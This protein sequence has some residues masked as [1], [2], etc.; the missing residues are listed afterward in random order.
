MKPKIHINFYTSTTDD[1]N[2]YAYALKAEVTEV[3]GI[4]DENGNP[5]PRIFIFQRGVGIMPNG[6]KTR[7]VFFGI[8][9]PLDMQEIPG[10]EPDLDNDLPFYRLNEVTL[11]F[12]CLSD[13]EQA[14]KD[15]DGDITALIK[16]YKYLDQIKNQTNPTWSKTYE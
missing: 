9:T 6:S 10:D 8:A 16:T 15:I 5:D 4:L 2:L 14:K 11:W 3:E 12:R 13:L 7:D 1:K